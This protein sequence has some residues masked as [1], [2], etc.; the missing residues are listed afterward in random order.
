ME[1][2]RRY[3]SL[4]DKEEEVTT[5]IVSPENQENLVRFQGGTTPIEA[6]RNNIQVLKERALSLL[7]DEQTTPTQEEVSEFPDDWEKF[8]MTIFDYLEE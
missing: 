5:P 3:G 7:K 6:L 8:Q 2:K 1:T 4:K